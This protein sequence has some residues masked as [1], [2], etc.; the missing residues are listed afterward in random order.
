MF[1]N[2]SNKKLAI[3]FA[4]LLLIAA[5][6]IIIDK[7]S[8]DSTFNQVLVSIDS[9]KITS[10]VLY[11]KAQNHKEVRLIKQ[12]G[13]WNVKTASNK[14]KP[15]PPDK[16][17]ELINAAIKIEPIR[18]AAKSETKWKEYQVDTSGTRVEFYDGNE[19]I[20][21]IVIG[22]F[23]FQQPR[24]MTTFVRLTDEKNV[25]A[26]DGFL[27]FIFN[28]PADSFRNE[29]LVSLTSDVINKV[30]LNYKPDTSFV[31]EKVNDRWMLNGDAADSAKTV[32]Y[33]RTLSNLRSNEFTD[34]AESGNP[35]GTLKIESVNNKTT[36][37]SI[38]PGNVIASSENKD[39]IFRDDKLL[40]QII[41]TPASFKK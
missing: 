38:Y 5:V 19:K 15:V 26:V 17:N 7:K 33:L 1:S 8:N 40:S 29:T 34:N 22:K 4:V 21:D 25:Y 9:T 31:L 39:E 35:S 23:T 13:K 2:F 20:L 3:T 32:E 12:N 11:P 14:Y 36:T 30:T 16:I 10:I 28:K 6:V 27:E 41:K 37:I 18:L 24:N